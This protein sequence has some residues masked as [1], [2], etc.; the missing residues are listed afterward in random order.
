MQLAAMS[1][2]EPIVSDCRQPSGALMSRSTLGRTPWLWYGSAICRV[3]E[4]AIAGQSGAAGASKA[5]SGLGGRPTIQD[6]HMLPGKTGS[7]QGR[8]KGML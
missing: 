7:Q 5:T 4:I 1:R 3:A 6:R 2:L 8:T